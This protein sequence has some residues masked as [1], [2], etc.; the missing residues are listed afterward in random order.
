MNPFDRKTWPDASAE[1]WGRRLRGWLAEFGP[2]L[3]RSPISAATIQPLTDLEVAAVLLRG[4]TTVVVAELLERGGTPH[5]HREVALAGVAFLRGAATVA[6]AP[7]DAADSDRI[8]LLAG[9]LPEWQPTLLDGMILDRLDPGMATIYLL[10]LDYHSKFLM[11][12]AQEHG[13]LGPDDD[14]PPAPEG[15]DGNPPP[16]EPTLE[17]IAAEYMDDD[18]RAVFSTDEETRRTVVEQME[19]RRKEQAEAARKP[20]EGPARP[21]GPPTSAS[22]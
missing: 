18:E 16:P 6:G 15:D 21:A 13:A 11:R 1:E 4:W 19:K 14:L 2:I 8:T 9:D 20:G 10:G 5:E 7:P 3:T 12:F 17:E 22:D